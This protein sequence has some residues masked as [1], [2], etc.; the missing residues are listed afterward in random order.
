MRRE[1]GTGGR[2]GSCLRRNDERG[3]GMTGGGAGVT[4]EARAGRWWLRGFL[5][6]QE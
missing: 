5:P 4:V 3:A 1:R 6:A 2:A